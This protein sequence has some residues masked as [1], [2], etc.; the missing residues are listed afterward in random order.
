LK[1]LSQVQSSVFHLPSLDRGDGNI[2]ER[3]KKEE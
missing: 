1:T 2:R 3:R